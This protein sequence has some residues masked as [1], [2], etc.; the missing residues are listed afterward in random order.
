MIIVARISAIPVVTTIHSVFLS[1]FI[2]RSIFLLI[3]YSLKT[4]FFNDFIIHWYIHIY[5]NLL[6]HIHVLTYLGDFHFVLSFAYI[7]F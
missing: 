3:K 1:H 2:I 6:N 5:H 7:S 4:S